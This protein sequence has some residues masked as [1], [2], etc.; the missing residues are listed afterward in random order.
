MVYAWLSPSARYLTS[1]FHP[2]R[3]CIQ[4]ENFP[5]VERL[6]LS[7]D[8]LHL[9]M[10]EV[11]FFPQR[12]NVKIIRLFFQAPIALAPVDTPILK[13]LG[14][15]IRVF[16]FPPLMTVVLVRNSAVTNGVLSHPSC[17]CPPAAP[18][19]GTTGGAGESQWQGSLAWWQQRPREGPGWTARRG[20]CC[21]CGT[22]APGRPAGRRSR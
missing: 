12:A 5:P 22:G 6:L 16:S 10:C 8:Q 4:L 19:P 13:I 14:M 7:P 21:W 2:P 3:S 18:G 1:L 20:G 15:P 9:F 17:R 11:P